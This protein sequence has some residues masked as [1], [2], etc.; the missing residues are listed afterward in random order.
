M[1]SLTVLK[2]LSG[3]QMGAEI[4]LGDGDYLIGTDDDSDVVLQDDSVAPEHV[5]LRVRGEQALVEVK[6]RSAVIGKH[7]FSTGEQTEISLPSVIGLGTTYVA[8]GPEG[9]DW[10]SLALPDTLGQRPDSSPEEAPP[11]IDAEPE[12]PQETEVD[13][14]VSELSKPPQPSGR[15]SS[16]PF[17]GALLISA[18]MLTAA[19]LFLEF[20]QDLMDWLEGNTPPSQSTSGPSAVERA[21][22]IL[23][24]LGMDQVQ[25][26]AR[27]DGTVV[28]QGYCDTQSA[29]NSLMAALEQADIRTENHIWAGDELMQAIAETLSRL[30]AQAL[31]YRYLGKGAISLEGYLGENLAEEELL[32]ILRNDVPGISRIDA[33]V[34][35]LADSVADLRHRVRGVGLDGL[36]AVEADG[37]MVLAEGIL[38]PPQMALWQKTAQAFAGD[39]HGIPP[40]ESRVKFRQIDIKASDDTGDTMP[41][42]IQPMQAEI[43][44]LKLSVRGV[45]IGPDEPGFALLG[46][47]AIVSEGD[48]LNGNYMIKKIEFNRIIVRNGSKEFVYYV[49]EG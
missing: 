26:S 20:R 1:P 44:K 49:G 33:K 30:G 23:D 6:D 22:A 42:T 40:L 14:M 36:V 25:L 28:L 32:V 10:L 43:P 35:T 17:I 19:V 27:Q 48:T 47:G 31:N 13:D 21:Q 46:N 3:P 9:T 41:E 8:L 34:R 29:E 5:L 4:R 45:V 15:R 24:K 18:G 37:A 12:A 11:D 2:L 39:T 7:G 38:D 16:G